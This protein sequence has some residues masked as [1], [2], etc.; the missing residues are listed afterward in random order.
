MAL[1]PFGLRL[2]WD[3]GT[4][5]N[6]REGTRRKRRSDRCLEL[7]PLE[8]RALLATV[9]VNIIN[10]AFTPDPVNI[11]VGDTV[12]WVWQSNNHST[13]SATVNGVPQAESWNSGV[14]N[15]G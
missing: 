6:T 14:L 1:L 8:V 5:R 2:A 7:E 4:T 12:H 13:T 15:L 9:T 10:F 11:N 3:H